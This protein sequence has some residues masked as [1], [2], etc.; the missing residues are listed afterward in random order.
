M[1]QP[2]KHGDSLA[3]QIYEDAWGNEEVL[4]LADI[5]LILDGIWNQHSENGIKAHL[6][7]LA[8]WMKELESVDSDLPLDY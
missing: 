4:T 3:E 5:W 8:R 2:T 1:S 7:M 6:P